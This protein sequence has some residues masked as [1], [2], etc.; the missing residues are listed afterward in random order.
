VGHW[1]VAS[2]LSLLLYIPNP[3]SLFFF[4]QLRRRDDEL[5]QRDAAALAD[6]RRELDAVDTERKREREALQS[7]LDAERKGR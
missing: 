6:R 3:L 1:Q 7:E 5:T 2:S 4:A